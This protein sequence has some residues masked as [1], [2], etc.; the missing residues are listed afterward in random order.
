MA[1]EAEQ[2]QAEQVEVPYTAPDRWRPGYTC[3]DDGLGGYWQSAQQRR[4]AH[5][6]DPLE[7]F[8]T[9]DKKRASRLLRAHGHVL[10]PSR[11]PRLALA[12]IVAR[13]ARRPS[14]AEAALRVEWSVAQGEPA[15]DPGAARSLAAAY[16]ALHLAALA[17]RA[18][19]NA[20][21]APA[22]PAA[23]VSDV[24]RLAPGPGPPPRML[25]PAILDALASLTLAT[26]APPRLAV[27]AAGHPAL[28]L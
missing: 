27:F 6:P 17:R 19:R 11:L 5:R 4:E 16:H 2:L 9:G 8:R 10:A 14:V 7:L 13:R 15:G 24:S 20:P 12:A 28:T 18:S 21:P 25:A 3:V 23:P 1:H 22:R 26:H